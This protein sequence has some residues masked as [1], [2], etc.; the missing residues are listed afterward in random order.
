MQDICRQRCRPCRYP[1]PAEEWG[2]LPRGD[3]AFRLITTLLHVW[4][5]PRRTMAAGGLMVTWWSR[6]LAELARSTK[7]RRRA[8]LGWGS[9]RL[10][11]SSPLPSTKRRAEDWNVGSPTA[12]E[13]VAPFPPPF[14]PAS[15]GTNLKCFSLVL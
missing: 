3:L 12:A 10:A 2:G 6:G 4:P 14:S 9:S 1:G 8:L 7:K 15:S 13:A 5:P 11:E